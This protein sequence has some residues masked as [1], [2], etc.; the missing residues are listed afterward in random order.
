MRRRVEPKPEQLVELPLWVT[1]LEVGL[2]H[3]G[4]VT[5]AGHVLIDG[6]DRLHA[7]RDAWAREHGLECA[8]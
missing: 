1:H 7:A 8:P 4:S 2:R 6:V 5:E 3:I